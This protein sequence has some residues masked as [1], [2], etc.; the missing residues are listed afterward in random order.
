MVM[1]NRSKVVHI[2]LNFIKNAAEAM[3]G[4][5]GGRV[6]AIEIGQSGTSVFVKTIDAGVGIE[7]KALGQIFSYGFTTKEDG[8]GFGLNTCKKFM[9]EMGGEISV[10]SDGAGKG[11]CFTVTFPVG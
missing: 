1:A 11:A 7:E 9:D 10:E 2:M 6:L 4:N 3:S 5:N 8:H